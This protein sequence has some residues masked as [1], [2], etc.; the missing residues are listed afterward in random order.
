MQQARSKTREIR[1]EP[2]ARQIPLMKFVAALTSVLPISFTFGVQIL[3][4]HAT[5]THFYDRT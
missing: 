4:P 2:T 1:K 3:P 5:N